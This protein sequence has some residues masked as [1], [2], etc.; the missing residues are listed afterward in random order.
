M[1]V[2]NEI[3]SDVN[4][5]YILLF[6]TFKWNITQKKIHHTGNIITYLF[7]FTTLHFNFFK[8]NLY[9][10]ES[11]ENESSSVTLLSNKQV[12]SHRCFTSLLKER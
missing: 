3:V 5:T 10:N 1:C 7:F 11:I 4:F 6:D 9:I 12:Q 2:G 8:F